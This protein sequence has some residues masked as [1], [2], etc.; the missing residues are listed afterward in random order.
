M[1][2]GYQPVAPGKP[3]RT[4]LATSLSNRVQP[5]I[6][7]DLGDRIT[8]LPDPCA[9]GSPLPSMRVEGRTD[10][11]LTFRSQAGEVVDPCLPR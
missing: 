1:D 7:Y 3:S 9:C 10:E 2:E 11:I 4:V 5:I 6:R 8:M